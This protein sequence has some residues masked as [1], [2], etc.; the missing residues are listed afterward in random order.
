MH[1]T[2]RYVFNEADNITYK[3]Y[4]LIICYFSQDAEATQREILKQRLIAAVTQNITDQGKEWVRSVEVAEEVGKSEGVRTA[5]A[6]RTISKLVKRGVLE[7]T[8]ERDNFL[9]SLREREGE[10]LRIRRKK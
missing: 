4:L 1:A 9:L 5:Q 3:S 8:A 10:L 2:Y 6:Y 7:S